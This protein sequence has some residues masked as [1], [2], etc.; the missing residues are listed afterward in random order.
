MKKILLY[1]SIALAL[2]YIVRELEYIG[3]RKNKSGEFAKLRQSFE[4]ANNFDI[5]VI[6]SSRAEGQFYTPIIDSANQLHTFNIGIAGAT[7]PLF[8]TELEAYLVHSKAPKY[9]ILN[10]DLHTFNGNSDTIYNFPRYFPYLDNP[11]LYAGLC[12]RDKRFPYFK[13][14]SFYSMPYFKARYLNAALRGW[15]NKPGKYDSDY[16]NGFAPAVTT[17][18]QGDLD[19]VKITSYASNPQPLIWASF[20]HIQD[21]CQ[22][23]G[24]K[25]IVVLAPIFHRAEEAVV[26]YNSLISEFQ[27]YA[28]KRGLPFINMAHDS[29]QF[30]KELFIDPF[31]MNIKGAKVFTRLFSLELAQYIKP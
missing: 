12:E 5:L 25:L 10:L 27:Q 19:T 13:Y 26:N 7:M 9:V 31:H 8:C 11:E 16:V 14:L 1:T 3:I 15:F 17:I 28:Q 22:S 24:I 30:R 29:I 23:K 21:I 20:Q 18:D 6:G 4:E 2:L